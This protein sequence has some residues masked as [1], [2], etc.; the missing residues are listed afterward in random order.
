MKE[1]CLRTYNS[2]NKKDKHGFIASD[3]RK[4]EDNYEIVCLL[5][6]QK[7]I[8]TPQQNCPIFQCKLYSDPSL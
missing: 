6:Q 1:C 8:I 5:S 2:L 4:F 7:H 3:K